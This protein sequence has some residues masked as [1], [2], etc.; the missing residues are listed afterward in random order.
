[1]VDKSTF[2]APVSI[3]SRWTVCVGLR[4]GKCK[5][6]HGNEASCPSVQQ[7]NSF[8][9]PLELCGTKEYSISDTVIVGYH[10]VLHIL[11]FLTKSKI[12]NITRHILQA[13]AQ[14]SPAS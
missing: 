9:S 1:M 6:V 2:G 13:G 7:Y 14:F 10:L 11:Y 8:W 5:C 12:W 3:F 4:Q